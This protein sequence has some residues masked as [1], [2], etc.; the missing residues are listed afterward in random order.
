[1]INQNPSSNFDLSTPGGGGHIGGLTCAEFQQQLPELLAA[2]GNS[3][4]NHPHLLGCDNCSALVRDLAYIADAARQLLPA[5][6][7]SPDVWNQIQ[8]SLQRDSPPS[9]KE[10][11]VL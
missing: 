8:S 1:M 7:P 10:K 4:A 2:G 11:E 5:H 3:F 6:D 9:V